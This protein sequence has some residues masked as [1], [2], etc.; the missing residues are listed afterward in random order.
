MIHVYIAGCRGVPMGYG[1]Y[2][3]FVDKL[4]S[5]QQ[6]SNIQYWIACLPEAKYEQ[7]R[8]KR[9]FCVPIHTP[10]AGPATMPLMDILALRRF[11]KMIRA[12]GSQETSIV[13]ILACR[14][15]PFLRHYAKKLHKLGVK[16][17]LNPDGHEWKRG[18]WSPMIRKYWKLSERLMVKN[19]DLC[20][21]DSRGIE[22]YIQ[23]EYAAYSRRSTFISDA[24]GLSASNCEPERYAEWCR[25][26]GVH[27]DSYFLVIGRFV[28]ENNYETII[29][30]FM[31]S[32]TRRQLV[33]LTNASENRFMRALREKTGFEK[34]K[35]IVFAGTVYEHELVK[36]IREG[37]IAYIHGHEV[38]GTN[39]S[40]L[41]A[42]ASTQVNLLY[43]VCYNREVGEDAALYFSKTDGSLRQLIEVVEDMPNKKRETFAR[44]AKKRIADGYLCE[45]ISQKYEKLFLGEGMEQ[46]NKR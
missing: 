31:A 7:K 39:P 10:S 28:P 6:N 23:S 9:A 32:P 16:V 33:I 17:L 45:N 15:G 8:Y 5:Y 46:V 35:R 19:A 2:E 36:R 11:L 42:L 22:E 43:D 18:K 1:G 4:V 27:P 21:C 40:L 25:S 44:K 13:Y 41:E 14:I 26:H 34:D 12:G 20:V 37:A 30:E 24:A 3:S 38:G 29:R